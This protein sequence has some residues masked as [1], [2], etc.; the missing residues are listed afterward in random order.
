MVLKKSSFSVLL[1]SAL[2]LSGCRF[3]FKS[4]PKS[5]EPVFFDA[6]E[7]FP[8][9]SDYSKE[10][11]CRTN[12]MTG[13]IFVNN[14][15][16]T[17]PSEEI[18][19]SVF[20]KEE[21]V[22]RRDFLVWRSVCGPLLKNL[23]LEKTTWNAHPA[24]CRYSK[25]K[26]RISIEVSGQLS[27]NVKLRP[28]RQYYYGYMFKDS[29]KGFDLSRSYFYSSENKVFHNLKENIQHP[30]IY[31]MFKSVC[32]NIQ[33]SRGGLC[34]LPRTLDDVKSKLNFLKS[35]TKLAKTTSSDLLK[36][37]GINLENKV[38]ALEDPVEGEAQVIAQQIAYQCLEQAVIEKD[39]IGLAS[40]TYIP[41]IES[42]FNDFNDNFLVVDRVKI[43]GHHWNV[44]QPKIT[45]EG[46]K[47][48]VCGHLDHNIRYNQNDKIDYKYVYVD[49]KLTEEKV[50][51]DDRNVAAKVNS[52]A[53]KFLTLYD[54]Y[55]TTTGQGIEFHSALTK[56]NF[57]LLVEL[58][59][60][61]ETI[62]YGDWQIAGEQL[63]A[64]L[65]NVAKDKA[66]NTGRCDL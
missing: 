49:G 16:V 55:R 25:N 9:D 51:I 52:L 47:T 44:H 17:D 42:I 22:K 34:P 54:I 18:D 45:K 24:V 28:D 43:Y 53:D 27:H 30:V 10:T 14:L 36:E 13:G 20:A 4:E 33:K 60:R 58:A 46:S 64:V 31:S 57:K 21:Q 62:A 2:M 1:F 11:Y 15:I 39:S 63:T 38:P 32:D 50:K 61:T 29:D 5:E 59:A 6:L 65:A 41:T 48:T 8:E 19:F 7:N 37:F 66:T 3:N 23:S 40:H 12:P 56:A 26:D 35:Q